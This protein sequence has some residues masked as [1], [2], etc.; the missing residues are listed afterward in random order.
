MPVVPC[1]VKGFEDVTV[2]YPDEW[3]MGHRDKF[4]RGCQKAR[5]ASP[6]TMETFGTLELCQVEIGGERM[7][8]DLSSFEELPLKWDRF[9]K[10][11]VPT[12][13]GS[14]RAESEPDPNS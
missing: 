4:Y 9:F 2:T 12:V 10:W 13:Y 8:L 3:N 7:A 14:Y 5:L 11:L 6:L 1:P